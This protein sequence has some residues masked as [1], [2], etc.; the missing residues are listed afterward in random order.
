MNIA[1]D[2]ESGPEM[3][4]FPIVFLD[5]PLGTVTKS[6]GAATHTRTLVVFSPVLSVKGCLYGPEYDTFNPFEYSSCTS[7]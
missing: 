2:S 5:F 6:S 1:I 4:S 7:R 3:T